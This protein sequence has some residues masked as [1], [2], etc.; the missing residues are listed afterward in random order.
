MVNF[1]HD[2]MIDFPFSECPIFTYEYSG[3]PCLW[4]FCYTV[5]TLCSGLFEIRRFAVLRIYSD[6]CIVLE[7]IVVQFGIKLLLLQ[8]FDTSM[9][10]MSH[11]VEG[12]FTN[13]DI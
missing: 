10:H 12:L 4:C 9:S 7:L 1:T 8:K 6:N 11:M 13:C 3:I 5:D 2:S